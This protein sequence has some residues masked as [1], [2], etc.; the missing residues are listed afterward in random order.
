MNCPLK[1][2]GLASL[3]SLSTALDAPGVLYWDWQFV[4]P[5]Q[6]VSPTDIVSFE[7]TIFNG[8]A[9]TENLVFKVDSDNSHEGFNI[10]GSLGFAAGEYDHVW[11]SFPHSDPLWHQFLGLDLAP[12]ESFTFDFFTF[13]PISGSGTDGFS[14]S[15]QA[16]LEVLPNDQ[17]RDR[18]VP[19]TAL[20]RDWSFV[21]DADQPPKPVPDKGGTA[22]LLVIASFV[23]I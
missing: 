17:S 11:G 18:V 13:Y 20:S 3:I 1:F 6:T 2:A 14:L 16:S 23:F 9:S 22:A 12:G 21:V 8:A 4:A 10:L 15:N 19:A 5:H 7:A